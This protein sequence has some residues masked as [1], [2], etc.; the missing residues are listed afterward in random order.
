M[1]YQLLQTYGRGDIDIVGV[2]GIFTGKDAFEMLLCGA[3]AVQVGTCHWVEGSACFERIEREL[4]TIMD[5]K[6]YKSIEEFRGKLKSY[7]AKVSSATRNV[8]Q[9]KEKKLSTSKSGDEKKSSN[10]ITGIL[11]II[12]VALIAIILY[13]KVLLSK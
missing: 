9:L 1:I 5:K 7:D 12:I 13:D 6:G 2:G 3:K 11:V 4:L 10:G 8:Y